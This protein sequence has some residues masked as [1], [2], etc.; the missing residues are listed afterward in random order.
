MVPGDLALVKQRIIDIEKWDK[1]HELALSILSIC[2]DENH[3]SH[4]DS[5]I[6][7]DSPH[8]KFRGFWTWLNDSYRI[9]YPIVIANLENQFSDLR[10]VRITNYADLI[11]ISGKLTLINTQLNDI[12]PEYKKS[13][14]LLVE[15][16][17]TCCSNDIA[18]ERINAKT[19][20]DN[21]PLMITNPILN[22]LPALIRNPDRSFNYF[23]SRLGTLLQARKPIATRIISSISASSPNTIHDSNDTNSSCQINSVNSESGSAR[24]TCYNCLQPGHV[25]HRPDLPGNLPG[26]H[27]GVEACGSFE[28]AVNGRHDEGFGGGGVKQAGPLRL[29]RPRQDTG[30]AQEI[31][32]AV[33]ANLCG[34]AAEHRPAAQFGGHH[35]DVMP[36]AGGAE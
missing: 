23:I 27:L 11:R 1:N 32:R 28:Q 26:R 34:G 2:I 9:S 15:S 12:D 20:F 10:Q 24:I 35:D 30:V 17:S 33:P 3:R 8:L 13:V 4:L 19:S 31:E 16:I 36:L 6:M 5:Q 22:V 21:L 18:A 14:N 29:A 7:Y 25:I